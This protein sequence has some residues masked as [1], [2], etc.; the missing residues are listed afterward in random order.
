MTRTRH[1]LFASILL[2]SLC[3][4]LTACPLKKQKKLDFQKMDMQTFEQAMQDTDID[5]YEL[6]YDDMDTLSKEFGEG[7][8]A[9]RIGEMNGVLFMYLEYSSTYFV[10]EFFVE[11]TNEYDRYYSEDKNREINIWVE[12]T[13]GYN[14]YNFNRRG[15]QMYGGFYFKDNTLVVVSN[16]NSAHQYSDQALIDSFLDRINYPKP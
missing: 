5:Y 3:L 7:I 11:L 10:H 6:S 14:I 8:S 4:S 9:G 13:M 1:K 12:D 16:A 2:V 15:L